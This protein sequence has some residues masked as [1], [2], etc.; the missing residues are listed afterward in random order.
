MS[1]EVPELV[2]RAQRLRQQGRFA[3]AR[4]TAERALEIEPDNAAAWFNLGAALGA[5]SEL[6]S[7]EAA[8]RRALQT[9]PS[10][11]EAWSNLAGLLGA[12]GRG[13]EQLAAYRKAIEAN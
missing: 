9:N 7:A 11:P 6:Q 3:D 5:L 8:Y 13:E 1:A 10:Y 2:A 12:T 4:V